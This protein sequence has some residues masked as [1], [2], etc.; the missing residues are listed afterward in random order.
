VKD[1]Q[2]T[3]TVSINMAV[4]SNRRL[5][6]E[7]VDMKDM[8]QNVA[9]VLD[10][11][12]GNMLNWNILLLPEK[13]PYNKGAFKI[14][15]TFPAEYPFK[16]PKIVFNTSIYHPNID[17]KGQ[18]CLGMISPE[19]WKPAT[20]VVQVITA[21]LDLICDPELDHPLRSDLAEEYRNDKKKFFKTA[22]DHTKRH[23]EKRPDLN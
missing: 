18:V 14:S 21:L 3:L 15:V 13:E 6:K 23:S 5:Q 19:N 22:E 11:N 1:L 8:P 2:E 9:R 10:L 16:P 7:L 4:A 12:E 17:E 20:R